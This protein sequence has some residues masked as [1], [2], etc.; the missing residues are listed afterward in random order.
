MAIAQFDVI[1]AKRRLAAE[2][3]R[4]NISNSEL[5]GLLGITPAAVSKALSENYTSFLSYANM[6]LLAHRFEMRVEELF[7]V[8]FDE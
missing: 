5:A 2:L 7:K 8:T 3:A 4:R 1:Q 6:V